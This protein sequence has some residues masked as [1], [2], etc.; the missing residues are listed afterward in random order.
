MLHVDQLFNEYLWGNHP[1]V[2]ALSVVG[3]VTLFVYIG[4]LQKR[5]YLYYYFIVDGMMFFSALLTW[6]AGEL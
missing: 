5:G 3:V 2:I 4:S 6:V 1:Q